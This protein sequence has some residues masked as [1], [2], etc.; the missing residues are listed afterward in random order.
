MWY[1]QEGISEGGEYGFMTDSAYVTASNP[2]TLL[3]KPSSRAFQT[4]RLHHGRS[5]FKRPAGYPE[6]L[7]PADINNNSFYSFG[8]HENLRKTL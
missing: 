3:V 7:A 5:V 8:A 4:Y 6:A 2:N 1:P